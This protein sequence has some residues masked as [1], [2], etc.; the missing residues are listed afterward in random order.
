[1]EAGLL[2]LRN[3]AG[4]A[5]RQHDAVDQMIKGGLKRDRAAGARFFDHA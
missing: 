3:G 1:M 5:G 4:H 2:Q